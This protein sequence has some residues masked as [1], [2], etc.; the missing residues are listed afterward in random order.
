MWQEMYIYKLWNTSKGLFLAIA[1]FVFGQ[2][3]FIYK[4]ILNFPFFP[5][6]MYAHP[7]KT[8]EKSKSY[9]IYVNGQELIYTNLP[10]WTEGNILNTIKYYQKY[11]TGNI[12]AKN[13]W[14]QRFGHPNTPLEELI[15][16]RLVPSEKQ[17][18][19]Y[20]EWLAKYVSEQIGKPVENIQ[21]IQKSYFYENQ[22]WIPSDDEFIILDYTQSSI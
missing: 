9:H 11:Q 10:N 4:G 1:I 2:A 15:Y 13:A 22:R 7:Q 20:P 21:V 18:K 14:I 5:F 19:Q 16:H 17:V 3:F 8:P 12:W 6:E